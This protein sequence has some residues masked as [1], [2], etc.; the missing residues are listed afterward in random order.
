MGRGMGVGGT[1]SE[2]GAAEAVSTAG[3]E[4][5]QQDG[6]DHDGQAQHEAPDSSLPGVGVDVVVLTQEL[7]LQLSQTGDAL[8]LEYL[9][10]ENCNPRHRD[11]ID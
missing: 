2:D 7:L 3:C 11:L 1:Y 5:S 10:R 4:Q 6:E 8:A 9:R